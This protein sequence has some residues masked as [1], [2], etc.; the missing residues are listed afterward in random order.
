MPFACNLNAIAPANRGRYQ[1]LTEHLLQAVE[2]TREFEDGYGFRL[3]QDR[4]RPADIVEWI[5]FETQCCPFFGIQ[6]DWAPEAGPL[7]LRLKGSE[8]VKDLI[9]LE[10]GS[11]G[12]AEL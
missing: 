10:F 5:A 8:G 7:W 9:R 4:I 2:E 1:E 3:A 11:A 6:L 12:L